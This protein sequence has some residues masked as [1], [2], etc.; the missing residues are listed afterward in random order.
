MEGEFGNVED[1]FTNDEDIF[2][3]VELISLSDNSDDDD[4]EWEKRRKRLCLALV[5]HRSIK[6]KGMKKKRHRTKLHRDRRLADMLLQEGIDEGLFRVEY[7][8]SP[9]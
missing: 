6:K 4:D 3:E 9:E 7:R 1:V 8:L 5:A 2:D